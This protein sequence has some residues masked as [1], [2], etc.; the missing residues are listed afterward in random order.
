MVNKWDIYYCNLDPTV[1]SEQRGTR[2]VLIIS[3]NSVN[4]HLPVSTVLPI[5]SVKPG[6]KIYPTEVFLD[7]S[8]SGLPKASIAMLQQ[9]RTISH[10]RLGRFAGSVTDK[11]TQE[12]ILS[13]CRDYFDL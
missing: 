9:I 6:A 2:P 11:K 4:H 3:T 7:P 1:G 12:K 5:S 8:I 10:D 13:V